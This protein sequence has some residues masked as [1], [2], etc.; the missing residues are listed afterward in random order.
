[1][2]LR[3]VRC[4]HCSG[5]RNVKGSELIICDVNCAVQWQSVKLKKP[6]NFRHVSLKAINVQVQA[7]I[8]VI[9]GELKKQKNAP[10]NLSRT[11]VEYERH[12]EMRFYPVSFRLVEISPRRFFFKIRSIFK[13]VCNCD[14]NGI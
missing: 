5:L 13:I 8:C 12:T 4:I 3:I 10:E 9:F 7:L 1:M 11:A 14:K 2:S 6:N